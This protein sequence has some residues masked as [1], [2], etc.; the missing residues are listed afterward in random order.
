M[1][2]MVIAP[3]PDDA[4]LGMGGSIVRFIQQ[5][6]A[7]T[8]VDATDGEPTPHGDPATRARE[9]AEANHALGNPARLNLGMPNRWLEST[10]ENRIKLAEAIRTHRPEVMFAPFQFDS[11]PDHLALHLLAQ[12]A[13]FTAKYTRTD[14]AG[15][16]HWPRRLIYYFCTHLMIS[17]QPTFV[18]DISN[19]IDA[20]MQ[21]VS[22]YQSQFY[23]G[24]NAGKVPEMVRNMCRYFGQRVGAQYAE[25]FFVQEV[26]GL[27]GLDGVM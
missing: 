20:K 15:E 12:Q 14:M 21:A 26:L 23:R 9:T 18:I 19:Q 8:I 27:S 2:I 1:N 17:I 22:A 7:V 13:R 3:H 4:E 5:G 16:P 10:I 24:E 11:H 6:H 25:P